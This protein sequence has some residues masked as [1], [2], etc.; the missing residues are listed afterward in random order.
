MAS[1]L[2]ET[3]GV[4]RNASPEQSTS[5][6]SA[7]LM[8]AV[9]DMWLALVRKAYKKMALQTHPDRLSPNATPD[10]K[11]ASEERFRQVSMPSFWGWGARND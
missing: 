6:S 7:V 2:Y 9:A 8:R 4:A 3:L 5:S 1:N 11:A 10:D